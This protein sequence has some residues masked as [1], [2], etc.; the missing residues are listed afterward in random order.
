MSNAWKE[1][2]PWLNG[3]VSK[4][5]AGVASGPG[6]GDEPL[7]AGGDGMRESSGSGS[8][9]ELFRSRGVYYTTDT[10]PVRPLDFLDLNINQNPYL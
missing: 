9:T 5:V 1:T 6:H 3:R 7:S 10:W 2:R 8:G 4:A